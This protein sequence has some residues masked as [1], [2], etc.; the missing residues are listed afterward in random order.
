MNPD[1]SS[2]SMR[3]YNM[4]VHLTSPG[5]KIIEENVAVKNI[6]QKNSLVFL[7]L[8][9]YRTKKSHIVDSV[10]LRDIADLTNEKVY[11]SA[12]DFIKDYCAYTAMIEKEEDE[13]EPSQFFDF[14]YLE[15]IKDNL[16]I[17][18]FIAKCTADFNQVK[19]ASIRTYINKKLPHTKTLSEQYLNNY[20]AELKPDENSFF[21]AIE[22]L[23]SKTPEEVEELIKEAL[24]ISAADGSLSYQERYYIAEIVQALREYGIEPDIDF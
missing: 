5:H 4:L 1:S 9:F 19:L 15:K 7:D 2:R 3:F 16:I 17:L 24:K 14:R 12:K 11:T 13:E 22:A 20:M 8:Y 23:K 21:S 10:Y 18:T 6:W